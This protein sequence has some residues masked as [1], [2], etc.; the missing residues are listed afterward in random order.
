MLPNL[1]RSNHSPPPLVIQ[2]RAVKWFHLL[3]VPR[4]SFPEV[5]FRCSVWS[6]IR[7]IIIKCLRQ[8]LHFTQ[9]CVEKMSNLGSFTSPSLLRVACQKKSMNFLLKKNPSLQHWRIQLSTQSRVNGICLMLWVSTGQESRTDTCTTHSRR[10]M[11]SCV[12]PELWIQN[13]CLVITLQHAL[14]SGFGFRAL[15]PT[16]SGTP[17]HLFTSLFQAS[18]RERIKDSLNP[19][20]LFRA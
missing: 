5:S 6:Q 2:K 19:E 10:R 20:L 18:L 15:L 1:L 14:A 8:A 13:Y 9:F 16:H 7:L 4:L 11:H 17:A 3:F 12:C